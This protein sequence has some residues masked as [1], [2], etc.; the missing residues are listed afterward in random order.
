ML[1]P[2][3]LLAL[4]TMFAFS[5]S[6]VSAQVGVGGNTNPL[7]AIDP[8]CGSLD[9]SPAS[10][11][12]FINCWI[13][14]NNSR[15][16]AIHIYSETVNGEIVRKAKFRQYNKGEESYSSTETKIYSYDSS[17]TGTEVGKG[18]IITVTL[19][20][21]NNT[22]HPNMFKMVYE[23]NAGQ[24]YDIGLINFVRGNKGRPASKVLVKLSN[25]TKDGIKV[26][27]NS[28]SNPCDEFPVEDIGE[29]EEIAQSQAQVR[30][31]IDFVAPIAACQN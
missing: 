13:S 15:A 21:V 5:G 17:S 8:D 29:E 12:G 3:S 28:T 27:P 2:L 4:V 23:S 7:P 22:S 6:I 31:P 25:K 26:T 18:S 11:S 1:R 19:E 14:R 10:S 30:A 20:K 16:I 24:K 9:S